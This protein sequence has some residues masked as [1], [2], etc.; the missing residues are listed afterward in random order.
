MTRVAV[1]DIQYIY[2]VVGYHSHPS[3][4]S[5]PFPVY[6]RGGRLSDVVWEGASVLMS[7]GQ[8]D[9][10][11]RTGLFLPPCCLLIQACLGHQPYRR[12]KTWKMT[13]RNERVRRCVGND[14]MSVARCFV[15][16]GRG[17]ATA[18]MAPTV[19]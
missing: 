19:S 1:T 13:M 14:R 3:T 10:R 11:W 2:V 15:L 6:P 16:G 5:Q 7:R 8:E 9:G 17:W 4:G 12:H 18:H